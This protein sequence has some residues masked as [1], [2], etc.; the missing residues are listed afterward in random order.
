MRDF[1]GYAL[2]TPAIHKY[3]S[4][5]FCSCVPTQTDLV[6]IK[7][8][9]TTD[10]TQVSAVVSRR[11]WRARCGGK[12]RNKNNTEHLFEF[13]FVP[14][15]AMFPSRPMYFRSHLAASVSRGSLSLMSSMAN[16]V[17]WR[18]SALSSKLIL[19]SK[20]TTV[21]SGVG[22][23]TGV[24]QTS[25]ANCESGDKEVRQRSLHIKSELSV[26]SKSGGLM[27]WAPCP[28]GTLVLII[29]AAGSV[30]AMGLE[31][32]PRRDKAL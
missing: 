26:V 5:R 22:K 17:F 13:A 25:T 9:K 7:S 31:T 6:E 16:T 23:S 14:K 27:K 1:R 28:T 21:G 2:L 24:R 8:Y 32:P 3:S 18:N 11:T 19:A 20:Q 15:Q 12:Q 4:L 30:K 29:S 10:T